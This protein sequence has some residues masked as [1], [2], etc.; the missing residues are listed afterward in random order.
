[1]TLVKYTL[2]DIKCFNTST[3]LKSHSKEFNNTSYTIVN[4][5]KSLLTSE[6]IPTFGLYRSVIIHDNKVIG[7]APPKS[8]KCD[9]FIG[10]YLNKTADIVAEE[11]IEGTMINVFWDNAF[12][13]FNIATRNTIGADT[14]FYKG[15][16]TFKDM[17]MEAATENKL[18]IESLD[19][20]KCY[21]FVVQ[22]PDNRIVVPFNKPQLYLVAVYSIH[23][24]ENNTYVESHV[25][26]QENYQSTTTIK[27]PKRFEFDTYSD[28]VAKYASVN[29]SYDI[30]G[31]VLYN[32]I[33]GE[34]TKLRNPIYEQV[35]KLKGNQP[36][37]QY[38]YLCLRKDG[39][40]DTFLNFY[41]E[42]KKDFSI[43]RY[44]IH[45]FTNN[46]LSNYVSCYI[47]KEKPLIEFSEQYR[48]NMF[49]LHQLYLNELVDKKQY[50][51][52][53]V[54]INYVNNLH[55]SL[56]MHCLNFQTKH[57][58]TDV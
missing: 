29:T 46:L 21:S 35:R 26:L 13:G 41:P 33:T 9:E 18:S 10:K 36:K 27:F 24:E 16:K 11:F 22:H 50:V 4:Y 30:V 15:S 40:V 25:D 45:L 58:D 54:V 1:M 48:T 14:S 2:S 47:K 7:F 43:F 51:A 55:P 6:L 34:R 31:V 42:N 12:G 44:Q 5:D 56:L 38:H 8:L 37:L 39:K 20:D 3:V 32:K 53:A 52:K 23:N 17:F 19:K 49:A 57:T 28:L